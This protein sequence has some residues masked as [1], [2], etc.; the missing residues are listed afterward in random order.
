MLRFRQAG[1]VALVVLVALIASKVNAISPE[2]YDIKQDPAR[3]VLLDR[4]SPKHKKT[5]H[6]IKEII[7]SKD[8]Y[9]IAL[10]PMLRILFEQLDTSDHSVYLEFHDSRP[11]CCNIAGNFSIETLDPQGT[12]HVAVIRLY[13]R[14]I[15]RAYTLDQAK[16]KVDSPHS[17]V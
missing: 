3:G 15:E 9:Q 14:N 7:Y 13:L 10:H 1:N 17:P 8:S 6:A 4:L 12:R 5:W 2:Q 11:A 16:V